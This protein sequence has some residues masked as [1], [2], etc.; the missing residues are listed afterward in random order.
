M[1]RVLKGSNGDETSPKNEYRKLPFL[2]RG[3]SE[4]M[5]Q[6]PGSHVLG[7]LTFNVALLPDD[8][9]RFTHR[10]KLKDSTMTET[11]GDKGDHDISI[12]MADYVHQV[13]KK[14]TFAEGAWTIIPGSYT[15]AGHL[16]WYWECFATAAILVAAIATP[17]SVALFPWSRLTPPWL[18]AMERMLDMV[19]VV[20]MSMQFFVAYPVMPHVES[21]SNFSSGGWVVEPWKVAKRYCRLPNPR[22]LSIGWFWIDLLAVLPGAA[23]LVEAF[24][25]ADTDPHNLSDRLAVLQCARMLRM[26]KTFRVWHLV[27]VWQIH[28]G[29]SWFAI[30]LV[31]FVTISLLAS[32][33]LACAW[34]WG[35]FWS[36][37]LGHIGT[38]TWLNRLAETRPDICSEEAT[39]SPVCAYTLAIYW[40]VMTLTSVGYG[41]IVPQNETE[42]FLCTI[43]MLMCG[44]VWAYV[45]ASVVNVLSNTDR[46]G[47]AF[48]QTLDDL[49]M[50]MDEK[51][52][53]IKLKE[54]IRSYFEE[55]K[56][57]S[58]L[59]ANA[60][61]MKGT[62]SQGLQMEISRA[63]PNIRAFDV[64]YWAKDMAEDA[65]LN[66]VNSLEPKFWSPYEICLLGP[67]LMIMDNG[68]AACK[69]IIMRRGD[70]FGH[71]NILLTN[72]DLQED[73]VPTTLTYVAAFTLSK[74]DL[75]RVCMAYPS[76]DRRLRRAQVRV[77][78][79]AKCRLLVGEAR[80][81]RHAGRLLRAPSERN[82]MLGVQDTA[83]IVSTRMRW[84]V[85]HSPD[86]QSD[87]S[88]DVQ[89]VIKRQ[90]ILTDQLLQAGRDR[91]S[92]ETAVFAK[93]ENMESKLEAILQKQVELQEAQ[94]NMLQQ[95]QGDDD[96]E[97]PGVQKQ[98]PSSRNITSRARDM[99]QSVAMTAQTVLRRDVG[100][101]D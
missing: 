42:Y 76:L 7:L 63:G 29:V 37:G 46:H 16:L 35:A 94:T 9:D 57:S 78:C 54:R 45:V 72:P 62:L 97:G 25:A 39:E 84:S 58:R 40:A 64:I 68:F 31:T 28:S 47:V 61:L 67:A 95:M 80:R 60:K 87:L 91:E 22:S 43:L 10:S 98:L 55:S 69:G 19:F 4:S 96:A 32:H 99:S 73:A 1:S 59:S 2:S 17:I 50:F 12:S 13:P 74:T 71:D 81:L 92:R 66:L 44:F 6:D 82:N 38:N 20:D 88:S 41:D 101:R 8:V 70:A 51:N 26:A 75:I 27:K 52:L 21:T 49:N 93:F 30:D 14:K 48:K 79:F 34:I 23:F 85:A 11:Y 86:W 33:W 83:N 77:A 15:L 18:M 53:H 5:R 89:H 65:K 36:N 3:S 100:G 24:T 56:Y 90:A